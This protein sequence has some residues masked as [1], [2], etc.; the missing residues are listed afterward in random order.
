MLRYGT[1]FH[2]I[3]LT[4]GKSRFVLEFWHWVAMPVWLYAWEWSILRTIFD[5]GHRGSPTLESWAMIKQGCCPWQM[6]DMAQLDRST[7]RRTS[8]CM[9]FYLMFI[10]TFSNH[11]SSIHDI[12]DLFFLEFNILVTRNRAFFRPD[13][14]AKQ[15]RLNWNRSNCRAV[16][17]IPST[18]LILSE[19]SPMDI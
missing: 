3:P 15:R 2:A 6:L 11:Q 7:A 18:S 17:R 14:W 16:L 10:R 9:I 1:K 19:G 5:E 12:L 4:L 13:H 8:Q